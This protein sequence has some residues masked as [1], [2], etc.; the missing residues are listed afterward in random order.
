M[1]EILVLKPVWY[2]VS[3]R[4][5]YDL[6][7]KCEYSLRNLYYANKWVKRFNKWAGEN[8]TIKVIGETF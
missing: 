4:W 5:G 3:Q 2:S 6:F 1:R 8:L 7:D